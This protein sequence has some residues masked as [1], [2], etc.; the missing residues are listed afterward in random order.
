MTDAP[1]RGILRGESGYPCAGRRQHGTHRANRLCVDGG[2]FADLFWA[3]SVAQRSQCLLA[4]LVFWADACNEQVADI[5]AQRVLQETGEL[6]IAVRHVEF[7]RTGGAAGHRG[8][9]LAR[10]N[11]PFLIWTPSAKRVSND[12]VRFARS[13]P[14]KSTRRSLVESFY[15][16]ILAISSMLRHSETPR[17]TATASQPNQQK[18][19]PPSQNVPKPRLTMPIPL[20]N[21][22][23]TRLF[24]L[25]KAKPE[26]NGRN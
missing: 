24:A 1:Q 5:P 11:I 2:C 25:S 17:Q 15:N 23:K 3:L 13:K 16:Y 4:A 20:P 9:D 10:A 7:A 6:G 18:Q 12:T 19:I 21:H 8:Y 26:P 14:A 22:K